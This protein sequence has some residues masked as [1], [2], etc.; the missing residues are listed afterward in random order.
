MGQESAELQLPRR[1]A[2]LLR[3]YH[4]AETQSRLW[5]FTTGHYAGK[6]YLSVYPSGRARKSAH[7]SPRIS[8][9]HHSV[10]TDLIS[11]TGSTLLTKR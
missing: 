7:R 4:Q 6:C 2:N 3:F 1:F 11:T 5:Q 10:Y 9:Y 8:K